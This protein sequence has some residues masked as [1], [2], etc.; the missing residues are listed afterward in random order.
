[1][2]SRAVHI[3]ARRLIRCPD[4]RHQ[5]EKRY[6]RQNVKSIIENLQGMN[7]FAHAFMPCHEIL[8][9]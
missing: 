6:A 2:E 8:I 3:Q 5:A 1:M 9:Y 4:L 7:T